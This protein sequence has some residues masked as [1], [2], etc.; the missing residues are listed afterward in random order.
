MENKKLVVTE[1][2]DIEIPKAGMVI[3]FDGEKVLLGFVSNTDIVVDGD[4][5]IATKGNFEVVSRGDAVLSTVGGGTVHLGYAEKIYK[6][7][8]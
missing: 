2:I 5:R 7:G 1:K 3:K 6:E 4:L 8:K